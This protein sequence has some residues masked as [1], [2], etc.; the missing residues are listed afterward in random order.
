MP[1]FKDVFYVDQNEPIVINGDL[2]MTDLIVDNIQTPILVDLSSGDE[3]SHRLIDELVKLDVE[4][5]AAEVKLGQIVDILS[6]ALRT[7]GDQVVT[8]PQIFNTVDF[9]CRPEM[10][11]NL[12]QLHTDVLNNDNIVGLAEDILQLNMD[13]IIDH[14]MHFQNLRLDNN[15]ILDGVINGLNTSHI[16]TKQGSHDIFGHKDTPKWCHR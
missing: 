14:S 2:N 9:E 15:L 12:G 6:N 5:R 8:A 4:L 11:C 3:L 13:Q 16:V 7:T 1:L 10:V